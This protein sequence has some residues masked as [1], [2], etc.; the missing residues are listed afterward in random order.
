MIPGAIP[1][2]VAAVAIAVARGARTV[3]EVA[4]AVGR[5]LDPTHKALRQARR[6]GLVDWTDGE[7][8]TL[9]STFGVAAA[10]R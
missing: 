8:G 9:H 6:A 2:H 4:L 1:P 3:R 7:H 10:E 5:S